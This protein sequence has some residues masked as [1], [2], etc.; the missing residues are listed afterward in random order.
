MWVPMDDENTMI[1]NWMYAIDPA[2]PFTPDYIVKAET[3]SGRGPDGESGTVRRQT[4]ENDWLIDRER[5][6][7]KTFTGIKGLNT[8]DLAVQESMGR[9]VPRW[10]EHLGSTDKAIAAMRRILLEMV[11]DVADG[12]DPIGIEPATYR[13]VLAAD[14]VL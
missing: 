10:R 3:S 4:R 8:Q 5:Q 7:T 6:R 13:D 14:T 12:Q 11:R 2:I 1:F 9:I